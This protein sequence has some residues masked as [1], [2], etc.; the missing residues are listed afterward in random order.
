MPDRS[1]TEPSGSL[2]VTFTGMA[3]GGDAVG[4]DPDTD[5]AVFAWPAMA[6]EEAEVS[7]TSRRS[8]LL[9]GAVTE[10]ITP[11]PLRTAAPCPYFG[12]CGGCQWQ[13]IE[14]EGQLR[15]KHEILRDQL[16]RFGGVQGVEGLLREPLASPSQFSY[17]NTSHFALEP[18][19]HSL[20][21]FRR[22]S[23]SV[24]AVDSCPISSEGINAL[25]PLV[26]RALGLAVPPETWQREPKGIMSVWNVSIR[27]SDATGHA[28]VVLHSR[29]AKARTNARSHR[30]L[31]GHQTTTSRPDVGPVDLPAEVRATLHLPRREVR[32]FFSSAAAE[33]GEDWPKSLA[34]VEVM[35]DG[36]VNLLWESRGAS[37]LATEAKAEAL[38]GVSLSASAAHGQGQSGLERA[39]LGGWVERLGDLLYWVAPDAFFQVN[40]AAAELL[41]TEVGQHVPSG[42]G[43]LVDAHSGVGTFALALAGRAQRVLGFETDQS[44]VASARWTAGVHRIANTEFRQGQAEVLMQR[45][46]PDDVPD[47]VILDPPRAGCHPQLLAEITRRR[48]QRLVYISCDP[49]TLSRDIKA[50]S[51]SYALTSA[52]VIDMFPQTYHLETVAVLQALP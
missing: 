22:E 15:F 17:R 41:L 40:T 36:T 21:Y 38:S 47:V 4:R 24:L 50:L 42:L 33:R 8:N 1:P 51:G 9:R 13:H 27:S 10:I 45:L 44:A 12:E 34:V 46:P 31:R 30:G 5:I 49:S 43:L 52:R 14:Y 20:G 35:D 48:P 19:S 6:G 18:A 29:S 16:A 7:V 26:N 3:Y 11:S 37:S 32:R 23:H 39:P 25:I 28:V 2:R